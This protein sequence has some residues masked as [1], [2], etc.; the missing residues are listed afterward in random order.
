MAACGSKGSEPDHERGH[1]AQRPAN[2]E[3]TPLSR[4]DWG[5]PARTSFVVRS[6][7]GARPPAEVRFAR[8]RAAVERTSADAQK[9]QDRDITGLGAHRAGAATLAA[10]RCNGRDQRTRMLP[11]NIPSA[12]WT[13]THSQLLSMW[14]FR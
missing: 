13:H 1:N 12:N 6:E 7:P 2:A 10:S 4:D 8:P 5:R 14:L 11:I 3:A 9:C